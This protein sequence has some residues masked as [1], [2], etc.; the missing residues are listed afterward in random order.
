MY[1][2]YS[3]TD[4]NVCIYM[5]PLCIQ[6]LVEHSSLL[7]PWGEISWFLEQANTHKFWW[8]FNLL[9]S[10]GGQEKFSGE[11]AFTEEAGFSSGS[12]SLEGDEGSHDGHHPT[13]RPHFSWAHCA[14]FRVFEEIIKKSHI[15]IECTRGA[16]EMQ[17]AIRTDVKSYFNLRQSGA[18]QL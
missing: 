12:V 17:I 18:N 13:L 8:H 16:P 4:S 5:L 2:S 11:E 14:M 9:L 10:R 1:Q 6:M 3:R 15:Y 7:F